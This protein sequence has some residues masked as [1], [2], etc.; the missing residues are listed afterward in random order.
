[1]TEHHQVV[2]PEAVPAARTASEP[3]TVEPATPS[4]ADEAAAPHPRR[5]RRWWL[6]IAGSIAGCGVLAV[7]I[8]LGPTSYNMITQKDA[9][10]TTPPQAAGLTLDTTE[11]A[12]SAA[13]DL[14]S[15]LTAGFNVTSS[16][17]A[18]YGDPHSATR[19]VLFVGGTGFL[20]QPERELAELFSLL[21]DQAG[22]VT[23]VRDADPGPL[24][25]TM[26]C[27]TVTSGDGDSMTVCGWADYG[28]LAMAMFPERGVD[29]SARLMRDLRAAIQSR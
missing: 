29:E 1:M 15:V 14:K 8:T 12:T 19:S 9:A 22:H 23:G 16:V 5:S 20:A 2:R 6:A 18:V 27:G 28:S 10:L 17:A 13:D 7:V 24:G 4:P 26:R 3:L 11:R 25:G 21:D